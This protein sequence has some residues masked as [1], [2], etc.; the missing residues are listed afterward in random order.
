MTAHLSLKTALTASLLAFATLALPS[1]A[2]TVYKSIGNYG[3]VKYSQTPPPVGTKYEVIEIRSNGGGTVDRGE[4]DG[5]VDANQ[6]APPSAEEQRIAQLEAQMKEQEER[7]LAE[8][9]QNLRNQMT[10]L[11]AG[12]RVYE[13]DE[14]GER[15]YLDSREMQL[16]KEQIQEAMSQY[17]SG[18]GQAT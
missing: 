16:K 2:T 18:N 13:M 10:N 1:Q 17:C 6:E 11:N 12:G 14:N 8:R 5:K 7:Q 15:K 4:Y 9:C 3:E